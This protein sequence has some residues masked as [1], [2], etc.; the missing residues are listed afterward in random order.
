MPTKTLSTDQKLLRLL[1]RLVDLER[2][3]ERLEAAL[4]A[5]PA[6]TRARI[7]RSHHVTS[8]NAT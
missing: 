6:P 1:L 2:R 8:R 7:S 3:V 4:A 5:A